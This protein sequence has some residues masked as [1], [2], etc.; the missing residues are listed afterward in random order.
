Q[1]DTFLHWNVLDRSKRDD[2]DSAHAWMFTVVFG[3]VD[4]FDAGFG[5]AES[6]FC[7]LVRVADDGEHAAVVVFIGGI[8][9]QSDARNAADSISDI[10][11]DFFVAAFGTVW[12]TFNDSCHNN[13]TP[14]LLCH[15][16]VFA[17]CGEI[18]FAKMAVTI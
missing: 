14:S 4:F 6:S 1:L 17:I 5:K 18:L 9:H 10:L 7:H 13:Q 3:H 11:D 12:Y 16:K 2:V 15:K 8:V